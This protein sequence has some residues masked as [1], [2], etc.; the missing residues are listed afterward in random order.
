MFN[1]DI[2]KIILIHYWNVLDGKRKVLLEWIDVNKLNWNN[3]FRN[4][5]AIK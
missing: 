5:N 2:I 4:I 1:N 3:L